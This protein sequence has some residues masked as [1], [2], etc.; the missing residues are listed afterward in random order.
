MVITMNRFLLLALTA[1]LLSLIDANAESYTSILK[2]TEDT[3]NKIEI[4]NQ[5]QCDKEAEIFSQTSGMRR[6]IC[7]DEN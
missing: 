5:E 6:E 7:D 3:V 2:T 1:G 4:R